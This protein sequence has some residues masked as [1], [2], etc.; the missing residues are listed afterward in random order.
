MW[1]IAH[2]H[3]HNI[4]ITHGTQFSFINKTI[5]YI[6]HSNFK[7]K[8]VFWNIEDLLLFISFFIV[9]HILIFFHLCTCQKLKVITYFM[10]LVV[11]VWQFDLQV[12]ITI[13]V[14]ISNSAHDEDYLMQHYVIKFVSD[15]RLVSGFL[16]VLWFPPPIKLTATI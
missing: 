3:T 15:L 7:I 2:T 8:L 14:V 6:D 16:W 10:F 11:I 4:K 5:Y 1:F 9:F 12:L 13:N